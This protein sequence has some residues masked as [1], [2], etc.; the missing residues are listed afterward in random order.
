LELYLC[1]AIPRRDVKLIAK[2]LLARFGSLGGVLAAPE[3]RLREIDGVG[4]KAAQ[5]LKLAHAL[6]ARGLK[7]RLTSRTVIGSWDALLDYCRNHLSHATTEQVRV[8]FL[9]VKNGLLADE[10]QQTGTINHVALYPREV[11]RRALELGAAALILVHNHPSGDP[12]P[13]KADVAMT[14]EI[15]EAGKRLGIA[16]HDHLIIGGSGHSSFRALGLLGG[17]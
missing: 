13:S 17:A 10:V 1:L 4:A 7:E 8:L 2:K 9:D 12:T 5:A 6:S 16:V 3:E 15:I 14:N 11:I